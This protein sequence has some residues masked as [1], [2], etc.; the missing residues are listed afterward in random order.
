MMRVAFILTLMLAV[1]APPENGRS[2]KADYSDRVTLLELPDVGHAAYRVQP[3]VHAE[4]IAVLAR[5]VGHLTAQGQKSHGD[6]CRPSMD[7]LMS[8][9]LS[10]SSGAS[11]S[12]ASWASWVST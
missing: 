2:L 12:S 10:T 3:D 8:F 6:Y 9:S 5:R 4:A 1:I 11:L 7:R